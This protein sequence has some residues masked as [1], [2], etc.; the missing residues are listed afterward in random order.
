[1]CWR[2]V[3]NIETYVK[4]IICLRIKNNKI[5]IKGSIQPTDFFVRSGRLFLCGTGEKTVISLPSLI[6]LLWDVTIGAAR[7]RLIDKINKIPPA[8]SFMGHQ[9]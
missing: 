5:N 1:M 9:M 8:G 6:F 3:I 4:S 7:H 2:N